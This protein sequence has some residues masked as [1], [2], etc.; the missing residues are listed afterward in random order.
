MGQGEDNIAVGGGFQAGS[1]PSPD[2]P[3]SKALEMVAER[4]LCQI[5]Q[6]T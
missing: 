2:P 3:N 5:A 1:L 6:T 4:T